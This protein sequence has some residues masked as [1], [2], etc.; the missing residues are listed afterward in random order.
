MLEFGTVSDDAPSFRLPPVDP[1]GAAV[2]EGSLSPELLASLLAD[3]DDELAAWTLRHALAERSRA[4]VFD[5]LLRD[6]MRIVG[7]RWISGQWGIAEEHLASRTLLRALER[8]R[9]DADETARIGPLAVLAGVAGEHHMIGLACLE[10]VLLEAGWATANLGADLPA[11]DL[12]RFLARPDVALVAITA[13][14][15][16]RLPALTASVEAVRAATAPH[17]V[18]VLVGGAVARVDGLRETLG[19][20]W[21]G[22]SLS[23]AVAF[24][25]AIRPAAPP[26]GSRPA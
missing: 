10:Q 16:G 15:P 21:V 8:I 3:G 14:D 22:A 7:D 20:E 19:V 18:P 6:A 23:E 4:E 5:G 25:A 13:M 11:A 9:P 12:G 1:A 24:A 17:R 26:S 2:P